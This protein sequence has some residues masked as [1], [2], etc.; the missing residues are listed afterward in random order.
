[1]FTLVLLS[2]G[3]G[4][5]MHN[6]VPKQYMLL[7][8]KPVIMHIL[9][10]M[11]QLS[12]VSEVIVVCA[13]EYVT[14]IQLMLNQYGVQKRVRFAPAGTSRQASV[15]SG[16]RLVKTEDVIIHEAARPFVKAEDFETLINE[17]SRNAMFGLDIPFTVIKGHE[18]V[19]GLLTRSE[20]VNVQLP[21]KFETRIL[22]EAHEKAEKEGLAFTEDASM[23]YHYNPDVQIKICEGLEYDIKLTTRMD[24][25]TGEQIYDEIF[26]RRK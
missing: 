20:L 21:Q 5:R 12:S 24:M 23:V 11:D 9:E 19:E 8:G 2:G 15:L 3:T 1:M 16:V 14:P 6:S 7:A 4:K 17:E 22:L 26:R 10:R 25:L 13:D 18:Y